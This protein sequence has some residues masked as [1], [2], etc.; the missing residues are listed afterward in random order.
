[1]N[2][3]QARKRQEAAE[4]AKRWRKYYIGGVILAILIVAVIIPQ[5]QPHAHRRSPP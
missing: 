4:A 2:S 1:M 5:L 3:Y